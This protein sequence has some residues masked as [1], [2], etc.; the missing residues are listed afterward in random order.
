MVEQ[1]RD[2]N[3]RFAGG[4]ATKEPPSFAAALDAKRAASNATSDASRF[5]TADSHRRA[6]DAHRE[7]AK[8]IKERGGDYMMHEHQASNHDAKAKAIEK[9][10]GLKAWAGKKLGDTPR[11]MLGSSKTKG[12]A[13]KY[14]M[15]HGG[16][17]RTVTVPPRDD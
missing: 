6:A 2:D 12:G 8:V 10:S 13:D 15:Q 4:G 16:K 11:Q 17:F 5:G 14:T 7:A 9:G 1:E 3:G